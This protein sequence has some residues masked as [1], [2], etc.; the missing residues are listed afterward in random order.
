MPQRAFADRL[1]DLAD[2]R[3]AEIAEHWYKSVSKNPRTPSYHNLPQETIIL[4]ATSIYKNLKHLYFADNPYQEVLQLLEKIRFVEEAYAKGILLPEA[5]YA[6][7]MMRR[8]IWL[9]AELQ[10][11]FIT[12]G[13]MYQA[14]ESIN[15]TLLVF[16]Y[17]I[18]IVTQK[19]YEINR[20]T[21]F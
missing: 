18:Y 9:F 14:V 3:G 17:A 13:D 8:H 4:Q 20:K 7:I 2:K 15:R 6:L 12:S 21:L 19:Y 16:D 5:V 11:M 1:L 10:A